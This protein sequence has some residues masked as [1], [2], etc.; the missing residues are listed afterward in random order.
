MEGQKSRQGL[1][2]RF[3]PDQVRQIPN[4]KSKVKLGALILVLIGLRWPQFDD[5]SSASRSIQV[6][7]ISACTI[8]LP[9]EPFMHLEFG[10]LKFHPHKRIVP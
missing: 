10:R 6:N 4:I 2:Y 9:A 5:F 3:D 1:G 7:W 8:E